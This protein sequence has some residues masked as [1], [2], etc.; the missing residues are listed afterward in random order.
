MSIWQRIRL[1]CAIVSIL[2]L[3]LPL[4]QCQRHK[5]DVPFGKPKTF[6]ENVFPQ[7][8]DDFIYQYPIAMMKPSTWQGGSMALVAL[9]W[10]LVM[11]LITRKRLE[12]RFVWIFHVI[13]VLL[14]AGTLY[15]LKL[16]TAM[17]E[18]LY[19]AYVVCVAIAGYALTSIVL[20]IKRIRSRAVQPE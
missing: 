15:W 8:N 5:E 9:G 17:G 12:R 4:S 20:L 7:D 18:W 13:E 16:F 19:G 3:F 14:A 2:A 6:P 1:T 10:P 11:F